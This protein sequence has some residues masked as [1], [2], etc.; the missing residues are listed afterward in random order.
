M[1]KKMHINLESNN[2][3]ISV[4]HFIYTLSHI[5]LKIMI[6]LD[7]I[8]NKIKAVKNHEIQN[9]NQEG[10][11]EELDQVLGGAEAEL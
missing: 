2:D 3:N 1:I 11:E 5:C 8:E 9:Q 7:D 6:H 10:Q 4:S